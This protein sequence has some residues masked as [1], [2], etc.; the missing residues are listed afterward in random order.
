MGK[1]DLE[2]GEGGEWRKGQGIKKESKR[3]SQDLLAQVNV[4]FMYGKHVLIK[5]KK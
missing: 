4:N 3:V 1:G 5:C 2:R